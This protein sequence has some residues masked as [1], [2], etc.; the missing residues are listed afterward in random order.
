MATLMV[1]CWVLCILCTIFIQASSGNELEE[2]RELTKKLSELSRPVTPE[3]LFKVNSQRSVRAAAGLTHFK[4]WLT[5]KIDS[6]YKI[7]DAEMIKL[8]VKLA[9]LSRIC[10]VACEEYTC[11]GKVTD[12]QSS[13]QDLSQAMKYASYDLFKFAL[14]KV[15]IHRRGLLAVKAGK[16]WDV[17]KE[18]K[19]IV[20][21]HDKKLKN[22]K[23]KVQPMLDDLSEYVKD[24]PGSIKANKKE[25]TDEITKL[26]ANIK[27]AK[28]ELTSLEAISSNLQKDLDGID[29]RIPKLKKDK[30]SKIEDKKDLEAKI[31][32]QNGCFDDLQ[33]KRAEGPFFWITTHK[34]KGK[35]TVVASASAYKNEYGAV[36]EETETSRAS[37]LSQMYLEKQKN[38]KY[39]IFNKYLKGPLYCSKNVNTYDEKIAVFSRDPYYEDDGRELWELQNNGNPVF[40]IYNVKCENQLCVT[41]EEGRRGTEIKVTECS[42]PND[43]YEWRLLNE[44]PQGDED[45]SGDAGDAGDSTDAGD[46]LDDDNAGTTPAPSPKKKCKIK[47]VKGK[48]CYF[49]FTY[50][51]EKYVDSCPKKGGRK[52]K[53]WCYTNKKKSSWDTCKEEKLKKVVLPTELPKL[54]GKKIDTGRLTQ[55]DRAINGFARSIQDANSLKET[56]ELEMKLNNIKIES[57]KPLVEAYER[58]LPNMKKGE[59]RMST[60]VDAAETLSKGWCEM[61]AYINSWEEF[62]LTD[63]PIDTT[64]VAIAPTKRELVIRCGYNMLAYGVVTLDTWKGFGAVRKAADNAF[65]GRTPRDKV[66]FFEKGSDTLEQAKKAIENYSSKRC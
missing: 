22:L 9:Q 50:A 15:A 66:S 48:C 41:I 61:K 20:A 34:D 37:G 19:K 59:S 64:A 27:N 44:M 43:N 33:T 17:A 23:K 65:N 38:G 30:A 16:P 35:Q 6:T 21:V 58:R 51:N 40:S 3:L 29:A 8:A 53:P 62:K 14:R 60:A 26:N 32:K 52:G 46:L 45:D 49:P 42:G 56:K 63:K 24:L 25:V 54:C 55:L 36:L 2:A 28:D 1:K 7:R 10:A 12:F 39:K 47:T 13:F 11:R 5:K 4:E 18:M 31:E 57:K